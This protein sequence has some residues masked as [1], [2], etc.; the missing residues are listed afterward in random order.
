M[1]WDQ[2]KRGWQQLVVIVAFPR[3]APNANSRRDAS[4]PA[5]ASYSG[6]Y[7]ETPPPYTPETRR[8]RS[9]FSQHLSC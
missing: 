2:I 5:K 8:E 4:S 1:W 7:E 9:D 3:T 6:R